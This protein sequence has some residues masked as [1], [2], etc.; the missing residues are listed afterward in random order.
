MWLSNGIEF[1]LQDTL[2]H[3]KIYL[4][5]SPGSSDVQ[6][7]ALVIDQEQPLALSLNAAGEYADLE[8]LRNEHLLDDFVTMVNSF[9]ATS[10]DPG[11]IIP[12]LP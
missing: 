8:R 5:Q 4:V 7:I 3:A 1:T 6:M 11:N 12:S 9:S 2:P 10:Y